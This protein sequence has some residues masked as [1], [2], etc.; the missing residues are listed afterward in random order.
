MLPINRYFVSDKIQLIP[1]STTGTAW[2]VGTAGPLTYS[3]ETLTAPVMCVI[4][5]RDG[6]EKGTIREITK[7]IK[8]LVLDIDNHPPL[9]QHDQII[10]NMSSKNVKKVTRDLFSINFNLWKYL[11]SNKTFQKHSKYST[12]LSNVACHENEDIFKKVFIQKFHYNEIKFVFFY[13]ISVN[14][15]HIN[16]SNMSNEQIIISMMHF[17]FAN[18]KTGRL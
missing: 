13:N 18:R 9:P 15:T 3:R 10:I 16:N 17:H 14:H 8:V 11:A 5:N 4:E 7:E 6:K 2:S 12:I 1:P